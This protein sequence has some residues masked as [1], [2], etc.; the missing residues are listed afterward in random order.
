MYKKKV[1]FNIPVNYVYKRIFIYYINE[2]F[3]TNF[4]NVFFPTKSLK[5]QFQRKCQ[6]FEILTSLND[7]NLK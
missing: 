1:N 4:R 2:S 7:I 5:N 6:K 3:S